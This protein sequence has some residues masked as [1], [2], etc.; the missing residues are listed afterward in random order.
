MSF[1]KAIASFL[2]GLIGAMGFGGGG[3]L[4]IYLVIFASVPQLTAQG[5]NL[6]FFI[7]C[8]VIS[9]IIYSI[10]KEIKLRE[11]YPV[12][13][14]GALGAF[15][16][17]FLIKG[18]KTDYLSYAFACLL[19]IMGIFTLMPVKRKGKTNYDEK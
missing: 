5:I 7:P 2:S 18:I 11:I 12:I 1:V 6:A 3:I 13:L 15:I 9:V 8:S 4:I 16:G 19:I 10:K 17:G 14:G